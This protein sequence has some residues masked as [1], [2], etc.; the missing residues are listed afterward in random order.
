MKKITSLLLICL[1]AVFMLSGCNVG[2]TNEP[3]RLSAEEILALP[4]GYGTADRVFFPKNFSE[5]WERYKSPTYSASV[6]K[7][8]AVSVK[9][10]FGFE[11]EECCTLVDFQIEDVIDE[12][13]ISALKPGDKITIYS[14]S[15]I[16]FTDK[17]VCDFF[18]EKLGIDLP[19]DTA[20]NAAREARRERG[21]HDAASGMFE[22]VP[23]KGVN[24]LHNMV[25]KDDYPI[26]EGDSYT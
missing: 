25:F 20:V 1:A 26:Q 21:D 6:V 12:Y 11:Q 8:K 23:K 24:Y 22:L 16:T 15:H 17:G 10:Y 2:K 9:Y 18:S 13:N 4:K 19:D 7:G 14:E 3:D 5:V